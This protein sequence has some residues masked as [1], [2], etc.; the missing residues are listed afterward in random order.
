MAHI[1]CP[2]PKLPPAQALGCPSPVALPPYIIHSFWLPVLHSPFLSPLPCPHMGPPEPSCQPRKV[3]FERQNNS[4]PIE[5]DRRDR[6]RH[7]PRLCSK[8]TLHLM[9]KKGTCANRLQ[10]AQP[11]HTANGLLF[12]VNA[13]CTRWHHMRT[14]RLSG[15]EKRQT[16]Y[17]RGNEELCLGGLSPKYHRLITCPEAR[18]CLMS[19]ISTP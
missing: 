7:F 5:P 18:Q 3:I 1:P 8:G 13:M 4:G 14:A 16:S 15:L 12:R 2:Y 17:L 19:F 6:A 9:L 11:G 10:T